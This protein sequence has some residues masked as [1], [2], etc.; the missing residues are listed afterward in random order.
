MLQGSNSKMGA[1]VLDSVSATEAVPR[2]LEVSCHWGGENL[3]SLYW[4]HRPLTH[5][6]MQQSPVAT[7][8]S[9]LLSSLWANHL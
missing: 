3:R 1:E 8:A 2:L 5:E 4:K 7:A 6:L 9:R